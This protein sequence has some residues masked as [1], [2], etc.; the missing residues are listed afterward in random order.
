MTTE[1]SALSSVNSSGFIELEA[2]LLESQASQ[3]LQC[4]S[5]STITEHRN[6]LGV[7]T[8]EYLEC[9]KCW[10]AITDIPWAED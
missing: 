4:S 9:L 7:D 2:E 6:Q 8:I 3:F 10:L 1:S 5:N